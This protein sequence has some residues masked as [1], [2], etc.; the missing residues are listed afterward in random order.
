[1]THPAPA[2]ATIVITG[3]SSGIGR[4]TAL[5]FARPG[6]RL[7]LAARRAAVLAEVAA[8]CAQRGARTLVVPTDV[9]DARAV[10]HL[11][12]AAAALGGGQIDVW[13]NNAGSG[14]IGAFEATPLAA[15]EQVLR[16]NLFGYL[17]GAY[18]VLPYFRRQ[19]HGTLINVV[20]LGAWLPEPY[21]AAY[22]ASKYGLRG[23]LDALRTELSAEPHIHVC[24]VHPAYIDT[25]GFQ[26]GAN[27]TG[28]LIKPAP[29]VF[30]AQKVAE[31]IVR[32]PYRPRP[33]TMVGWSGPALRLL[34][35]LA[36]RATR[37]AGMRLFL[38]YLRQAE[39]APVSENSLFSPLPA[40]HGA[41]VSGGWRKMAAPRSRRAWWGAAVI[42]AAAGLLAWQQARKSGTAEACPPVS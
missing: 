42:T 12:E 14:A 11:A 7:V 34:Y 31:A 37:W 28:R 29:P 35:T 41:S 1:M 3:A 26:H 22:S 2:S 16:V 32:L 33:S 40:P 24:D 23:L 17:Y 10:H 21:T 18:A 27:Y 30:P 19:G 8:E 5:A 15:H 6:I 38:G 20:S 4:A 39:R 25:P 9:T 36:P 13:V